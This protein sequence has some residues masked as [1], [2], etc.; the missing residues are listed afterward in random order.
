VTVSD[1]VITSRGMGT[2]L[3]FALKL[4]ELFAGKDAALNMKEAIVFH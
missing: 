4:L 2:A 1:N 3:P